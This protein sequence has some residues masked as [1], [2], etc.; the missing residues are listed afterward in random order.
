MRQRK[1]DRDQAIWKAT[2]LFWEKGYDGTSLAEL[3]D[4]LGVTPPSFYFA[5]GNKEGLFREVYDRYKRN[6]LAYIDEALAE[7]TLADVIERLLLGHA[8]AQT[9]PAHP[10][11]C[12]G[13]N[14]GLPSPA[15]SIGVREEL[16]TSRSESL[17]K[18]RHRVERAKAEGE[19]SDTSNSEAIAR[20]LH[21]VGMG[22][23]VDAQSGA[24]SI[25][26]RQSANLAIGLLQSLTKSGR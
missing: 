14:C 6:H 2:N 1:L 10:S 24:N 15:N 22:M 23:A 8:H 18:I 21:V 3:T 9:D 11:G 5:F 16:L 7:P 4:V 12:L 19:I 26:M 20:L 13:I 25:Q 17:A